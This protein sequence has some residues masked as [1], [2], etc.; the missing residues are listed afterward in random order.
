LVAESDAVMVFS[1][2]DRGSRG[3]ANSLILWIAG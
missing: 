3:V 2:S 1:A